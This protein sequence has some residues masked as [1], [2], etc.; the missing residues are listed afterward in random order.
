MLGIYLN[1]CKY[2]K[3]KVRISQLEVVGFHCQIFGPCAV[4]FHLEKQTLLR[5]ALQVVLERDVAVN[6]V[7]IKKVGQAS[8]L[9]LLYYECCTRYYGIIIHKKDCRQFSWQY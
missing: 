4:P 1:M 3:I 9:H 6:I 7:L 8:L 5:E 2:V